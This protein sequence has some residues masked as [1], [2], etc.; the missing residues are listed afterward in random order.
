MSR[1]LN[2]SIA[3]AVLIFGFSPLMTA[4]SA[5]AGSEGQPNERMETSQKSDHSGECRNRKRCR[6]AERR[7]HGPSYGFLEGNPRLM[8]VI[9]PR[10]EGAPVVGGKNDCDHLKRKIAAGERRL[11]Q[12]NARL[13][14]LIEDYQQKKLVST[15]ADVYYTGDAMLKLDQDIKD[16]ERALKKLR[17]K[18]KKCEE[19]RWF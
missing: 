7:D 15:R 1:M 5:F 2:N 13:D 10:R 19:A 11:A 14:Q 16:L 18:L 17:K 9:E 4:N 12:M 8:I 6:N 3:A